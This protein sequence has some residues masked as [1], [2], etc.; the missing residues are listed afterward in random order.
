MTG[1]TSSA[2]RLQVG[3]H[4]R[5]RRE[6]PEEEKVRPRHR[7]DNRRDRARRS[8]RTVRTS[9]AHAITASMMSP[10]KTT[11]FWNATGTNGTTVFVNELLILLQV[12]FPLDDPPGHRPLVDA[13]VDH[14]QEVHADQADQHSRG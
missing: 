2:K 6:H 8:A 10:A 12:G 4:Q 14:H 3:R 11:S 9:A 5:Q 1:P 7:L 13:E